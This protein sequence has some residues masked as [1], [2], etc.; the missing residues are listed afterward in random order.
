MDLTTRYLGLELP[1]PFVAGASPLSGDLDSARR[2]EDAGAAAIVLSSLF[3]EA[4]VREERGTLRHLERHGDAFAEAA[5][6]MPMRHDVGFGPDAYL[7]HLAR[8]KQALSVPVLASLNGT[9]PGGWLDYSL[10]MQQAGADAIELNVYELASD[11]DETGLAV[12]DRVVAMLQE[13]RR[14]LQIPIAVKLSPF[15][16]SL[17]HF[18]RRLDE[19]GADGLVVFNRFY[20]AD[21]DPEELE[22]LRTIRPSDSHELLLRLRWLAILSAQRRLSLAVTGGVH[23]TLDAVKA[24][25]A[26][27]HAVQ[28]VSTLLLRGP[29]Q[30]GVL[31]RDLAEWMERHG[32]ASL[33]S[34]RGCMNLDRCPDPGALERANY[35]DVLQSW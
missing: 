3:E 18:A 13:L 10:L 19:H 7:G 22:M 23:T 27:A 28:L 4:V 5:S 32:Y 31:R 11:P 35:M 2:L 6:F 16:S 17:S 14:Q 9:T 30:L 29:E 8:L 1:H 25:M 21:I 34:M 20:Q 15:Y 24:V 12:E 33:A 26:G